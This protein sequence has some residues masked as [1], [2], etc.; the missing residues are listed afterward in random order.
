[1]S[2]FGSLLKTVIDTATLPLDVAKDVVTMGGVCT[3][4][5][6]TYTGS[7]LKRIADDIEDVS[8]EAGKL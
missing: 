7:K 2:I 1:M 3:D 6:E 8:D 4:R 5:N